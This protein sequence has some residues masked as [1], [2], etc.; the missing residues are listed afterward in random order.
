[1]TVVIF[2]C[3]SGII[4]L[5]VSARPHISL[6]APN[7]IEAPH[8]LKAQCTVSGAQPNFHV[9]LLEIGRRQESDCVYGELSNGSYGAVIT[10]EREVT[11][12]Q[13]GHI[14]FQCAVVWMKDDGNETIGE[15]KVVK[16]QSKTYSYNYI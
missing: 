9:T 11:D 4:Y 3:I 1:M 15:K 6:N 10:R 5:I 14:E 8:Q 12:T 13:T 2:I 16:L 7:V